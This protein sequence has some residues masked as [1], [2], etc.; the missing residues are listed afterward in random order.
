MASRAGQE[1]EGRKALARV[2][3]DGPGEH[4]AEEQEEEQEQ[5]QQQNGEEDVARR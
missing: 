5:H 3:G 2:H 1:A 4:E